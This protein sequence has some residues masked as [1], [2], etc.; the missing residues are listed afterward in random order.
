LPRLEREILIRASPERVWGVLVDPDR[1]PDWEAGLVAV[2]DVHGP[3][4]EPAASCT[5]VMNFRGRK[6]HGEVQVTEAF[7]PHT[8]AMRVQPPLT[9]TALRRERLVATDAGTQLK[10]ELNYETRAGPLGAV[11]N[12]ALTRPRL[13]MVLSESAR[14]LKRLVE[15]EL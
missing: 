8:R 7:A 5:Q 14:N 15:S 12:V 1:S 6:V 13:A 11:L 4:D 10:L 9:V 3:L 2:E